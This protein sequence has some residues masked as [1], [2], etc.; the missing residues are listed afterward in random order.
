MGCLPVAGRTAGL[1][2]PLRGQG[3]KDPERLLGGLLEAVEALEDGLA[4]GGSPEDMTG[5]GA[6]P[7]GEDSPPP[8]P[9]LPGDDDAQEEE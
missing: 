1:L 7:E 4:E 2:G 8:A 9:G 3:A 5:E 6:Q